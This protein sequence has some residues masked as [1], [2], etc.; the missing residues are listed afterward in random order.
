[1]KVGDLVIG[2]NEKAQLPIPG[3][4]E[5]VVDKGYYYIAGVGFRDKKELKKVTN[6]RA[7]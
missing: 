5:R 7:R 6:A 1:M 3:T 2:K 4:I